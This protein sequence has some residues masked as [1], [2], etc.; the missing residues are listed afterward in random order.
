MCLYMKGLKEVGS[1]SCALGARYSNVSHSQVCQSL[2]VRDS[3]VWFS[4]RLFLYS[5]D[6][7]KFLKDSGLV[8][9]ESCD[10]TLRQS[11]K[12][13]CCGKVIAESD[14]NTDKGKVLSFSL[15]AFLY[16]YSYHSLLLSYS[17][18]YLLSDTNRHTQTET[19]THRHRQE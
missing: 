1:S 6:Y 19:Q 4:F 18:S 8:E 15:S 16:D 7:K 17:L 10:K 5:N 2:L 14:V 9:T 3:W 12:I 11:T 13:R